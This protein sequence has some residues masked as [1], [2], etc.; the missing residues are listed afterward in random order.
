[1]TN[2]YDLT[3]DEFNNY[4]EKALDYIAGII[5]DK[6]TKDFTPTLIAHTVDKEGESTVAFCLLADFDMNKR[7]E[8]IKGLGAKIAEG[9]MI[10]RC[11]FFISEAWTAHYN[12]EA[13][14]AKDRPMPR[15]MPNRI[16][17]VQAAGL[18]F[19]QRS[20]LGRIIVTRNKKN[21]MVPGERASYPY[22]GEVATV[23]N[24]LRNFYQGQAIVLLKERI[25][26][27]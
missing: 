16:E 13:F 21:F 9:G 19:D 8:I 1:M 14:E 24:L 12:Q 5:A 6:K 3:D 2:P 23:N 17:V 4:L 11:V 26:L 25:N 7:Y 20:N 10:A 15:D 27:N 18:S 22:G